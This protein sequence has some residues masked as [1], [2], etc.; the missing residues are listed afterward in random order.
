MKPLPG[1]YRHKPLISGDELREL[2]KHTYSMVEAFGLDRKIEKYQGTR[3]ITL[4]RWDLECLLDVIDPALKDETDYPDQSSQ[5]Y[6][7]LKRLGERLHQEYDAVYGHEKIAQ[8]AKVVALAKRL[9]TSSPAAAPGQKPAVL[10]APSKSSKSNS[11]AYQLKITLADIKPPVW[12]RV[13]VKDC[14]LTILHEIIQI[15]MGWDGYHL[16]AF[17]IGGEQYGE[18]PTGEMEMTSAR[19]VKLSQIVQAGVKK[20]HYVYDFGDHWEHVIQVEK[21][22]EADPQVKYPRCAKGSR[23][24]PPEDCGGAWG[25]GDFLNAIQNPGHESHEEM[26]EWVGGEFDPEAFDIEAVNKELASVR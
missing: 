4:Y 26:L 11:T 19:K 21:V 25:Y 7:A 5:E 15:V 12:R 17:E 13:E 2:K 9:T 1:D 16:W 22:L 23:A 10:K 14:T 8:L 6:Q 24:C 18:D 3:P 20:F